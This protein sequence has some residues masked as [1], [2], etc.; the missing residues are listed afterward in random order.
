M[1]ERDII[2]CKIECPTISYDGRFH[3]CCFECEQ[4]DC[5]QVCDSDPN[6][7]GNSFVENK[8]EVEK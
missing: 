3:K 1:E 7:C 4:E 5:K 6:V 8:I 2:M